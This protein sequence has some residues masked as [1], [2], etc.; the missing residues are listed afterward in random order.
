M[1]LV[2]FFISVKQNSFKL[3]KRLAYCHSAARWFTGSE[4]KV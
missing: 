1:T 4:G 3:N 2:D